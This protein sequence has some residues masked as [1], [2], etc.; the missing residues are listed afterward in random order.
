MINL[1]SLQEAKAHL[2]I[3][4]ADTSH[5]GDVMMKIRQASWIVLRFLKVTIPEDTSPEEDSPQLDE[6]ENEGVPDDIKAYCLLV[7]CELFANREASVVNVLSDA[8][9][10]VGMLRRVPTLE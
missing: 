3:T 7:V 8:F 9:I 4:D 2:H 5:D 1:V 10:R 6:W